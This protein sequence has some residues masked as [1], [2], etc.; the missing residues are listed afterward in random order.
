[1]V[2]PAVAAEVVAMDQVVVAE[3]P[4]QLAETIQVINSRV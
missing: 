3:V 1:M 2:D 4:E